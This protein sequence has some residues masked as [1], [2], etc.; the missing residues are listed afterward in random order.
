MN[1]PLDAAV[2]STALEPVTAALAADGYLL[3]AGLQSGALKVEIAAGP[4]ACEDCLVP[5]GMMRDM[6]ESVLH[7]AGIERVNLEL[8]YPNEL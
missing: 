1:Q 7:D 2:L 4:D 3:S 8:T 5:K 6:I